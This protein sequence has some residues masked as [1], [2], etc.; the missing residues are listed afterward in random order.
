MFL[1]LAA[2][3]FCISAQAQT[4]WTLT[5][6]DFQTRQ[7]DLVGIDDAGA[8]VSEAPGSPAKKL[9]WDELLILDRNVETRPP[10]TSSGKFILL[11]A[12]GDQLRGVPVKLEDETLHWK[13]AAVGEMAIS[14]R[15]VVAMTRAG[16]PQALHEKTTEDVVTLAN[17]DSVRGIVSDVTQ[18]QVTVNAN[19]A[20]TPVPL[21]SVAAI[22]LAATNDAP[23]SRERALRVRL[24]DDSIITAS[25][26]KSGGDKLALALPGP[27]GGTREV[28][29]S[30]VAGIE[31]V[32]GP[33]SW[34]SSRPPGEIVHTPFLE[35]ARPPRMDR[36]VTGKPIRFADRVYTRGVGVAPYTKITWPLG[37]ESGGAYNTFRTQYAI[38]GAGSYADVS[39]RI[40]LD[41]KVAHERKTLTA[42]ELS[43][44]VL[45]PLGNAKSLTLE[46]DFG[47][48][49]NVQDRVNF[50]EPALVK[51]EARNP[52]SETNPKSQ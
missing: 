15:Q 43:P 18:A 46:V 39:V 33:V 25:A 50:I 10:T 4:R 24:T 38:D 31:Q 14:L 17:G 28:P 3:V 6:S 51:F 19:G 9:K 12:G 42:G 11:L 1:A 41:G 35:T 34:L 22:H 48:N 27:G 26:I 16:S 37:G 52:K 23:W 20:A 21:E 36:T 7:V 8:S 13:T 47:G 49:Y 30:A 45:V 2:L 32:N 44:V 40:L 5:T 29:L